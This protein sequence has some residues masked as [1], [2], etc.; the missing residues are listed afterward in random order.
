MQ[1]FG[2]IITAIL[3]SFYF[4]PFEFYFMPG[5]NTKLVMAVVGLVLLGFSLAKSRSAMIDKDFIT[6][7]S[8]ALS[9]SFVSLLTVAFNGTNEGTFLT[10]FMSMLVWMSATYVVC[11]VIKLVHGHVSVELICQYLILVCS[12]QCILALAMNLY[13]PLRVGINNMISEDADAYMGVAEG[14]LYGIGCA[15]DVA[16]LKF[17]S[18]LVMLAHLCVYGSEKVQKNIVWYIIAFFVIVVIGNMISRTTTVGAVLALTYWIICGFRL[19]FVPNGENMKFIVYIVTALLIF[20]PVL[21]ILYNTS[22][23]MQSNIRFGFEGFFSLFETGKWQTGSNDILLNHMIV[24]PETLKTWIIGDGYAAN[25]SHDP[26]YIGE[27]YHGFYMGT[28]I[29]YL[30]YI[31]Y[32]GLTGLAIFIAYFSVVAGVCAK[33]FP[34]YAMMFIFILGINFI[35]WLKVSTDIFVVFAPFLCVAFSGEETD[36][37]ENAIVRN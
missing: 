35:G 2:V 18:V 12:L 29:G 8:M 6:V 25:P 9:V 21:I 17:S 30:R 37:Q 11:K 24:F 36:E 33:N 26:Y 5:V 20:V 31:F 27:S 19:K 28:D 3:T 34:S 16:G 15:L 1:V 32:F 10:Y 4:F 22:D 7:F 23:A 14:R 13:L